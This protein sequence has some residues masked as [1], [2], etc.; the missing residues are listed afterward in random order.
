MGYYNGK[1][2]QKHNNQN[3]NNRYSNYYN[4]NAQNESQSKKIV[5]PYNFVPFGDTI[6]DNRESR[7]M[8]YRGKE[9]L[10]SG[11]LTVQLDTKTPLIIPDGAHARYIDLETNKQ[12]VNPNRDQ[13]KYMHI[14]YDFL[15]LPKEDGSG[16]GYAI[17]GSELRGMIRSV[18]E[19]VTD[20]CVPF[21]LND[22][23]M[24]L[25]LPIYG[26]LQKRGLLTYDKN[27]QCWELYRANVVRSV[28]GR[29]SG[30]EPDKN[31]MFQPKNGKQSQLADNGSGNE[32]DGWLQYN[33]PIKKTE[34]N[35]AYLQCAEKI[36]TW[37]SN[38]DEPYNMLRSSILGDGSG[39]R[40]N[41][42]NSPRDT[43][44]ISNINYKPRANLLKALDKAKI[45]GNKVPVYYFCVERQGKT[46]VYLSNSAVGRIAQKR[47]WED[48]MGEHT[49][50]K[51]TDRL[52]PACMLFGTVKGKGMKGHLRITDA[53]PV[54]S[55]NIVTKQHTLDILGEPK[56]S[57]FEFYLRKPSPKA[58]YWNFD[59]YGETVEINEGKTKKTF[60]EYKDLDKATPRGRKMYWHSKPKTWES[61]KNRMN[62]TIEAVNGSFQ[63]RVY[64][65]QITRRQLE[66]LKWVIAL[67]DNRENSKYQ[68]KLGH[69]KPYGYGSVKLIIKDQSIR[70]ID[71]QEGHI[72][73]SVISTNGNLL[74]IAPSFNV[75]NAHV[76]ELLTMAD[77]TSISK[78]TPVEYPREQDKKGNQQIFEWFS[79]N[80]TN[81]K[82]LQVLPEPSECKSKLL[83][84]HNK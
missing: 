6:D 33:I 18:Y 35:I 29:I 48:I 39:K 2:N 50:C 49:S 27:N 84:G 7:E 70:K 36:H 79:K 65:D 24:S 47:K 31:P 20:S 71:M 14:E 53:C 15:K 1:N 28:K 11:W 78:E 32:K 52:C 54:N 63:F 41:L 60:V 37:K 23:P 5:N 56:S 73:Y 66:D 61:K 51:D 75:D 8:V 16:L 68:H 4:N 44:S 22:K 82:T 10:L 3:N 38:D 69:A 80:H 62:T 45:Q 9:E 59:F 67:G 40:V 21:L 77:A 83:T 72:T 34:Y 76:K 19:A 64:F 57:A 17:P 26:S 30:N 46:L 42:K 55:E 12:V 43:R 74:E 13:R 25:R 58:T 81:A